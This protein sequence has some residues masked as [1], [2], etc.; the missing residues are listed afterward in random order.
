M[1]CI[2]RLSRVSLCFVKGRQ[3]DGLVLLEAHGVD[4]ERKDDLA[5]IFCLT[6]LH[7]QINFAKSHEMAR[8]ADL[9]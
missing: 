5:G 2:M 4:R 7:G 3:Y 8:K 6:K 9:G 1:L